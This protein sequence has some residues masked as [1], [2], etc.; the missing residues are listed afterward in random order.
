MPRLYK[1]SWNIAVINN[2]IH[3][4]I[5]TITHALILVTGSAFVVS[6]VSAQHVSALAPSVPVVVHGFDFSTCNMAIVKGLK[7]HNVSLTVRAGPA[8]TF[9][10]IGRVYQGQQIFACNKRSEWVGIV[11][12]PSGKCALRT[13]LVRSPALPKGCRSGWAHQRWIVVTSG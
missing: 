10:R 11:F 2:V 12:G 8:A 4:C 13:T 9:R 5:T 7:S 6:S 1:S 3:L